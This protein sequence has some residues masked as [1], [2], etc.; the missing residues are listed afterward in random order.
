MEMPNLFLLCGGSGGG[1]GNVNSSDNSGIGAGSG[2]GGGGAL[3]VYGK[4]AQIKGTVKSAGGNGANSFNDDGAGGG[5]SGGAVIC[6]AK[7]SLGVAKAD[8]S[9]G[10][11]GT[12]TPVNVGQDGGSGSV[13]RVRFDGPRTTT[14]PVTSRATKFDGP[15]TDAS[16]TVTR[17]FTLTGSGNNSE[18]RIFVRPL[19][20][21]WS[22][23]ASVKNYGNKWQATVTLPGNDSN[24]LLAA[25]QRV[26]NP[27]SAKYTA[28][29]SWVLSQ[30]AANI[31]YVLCPARGIVA[32]D[33]LINFGTLSL[34]A[35][36]FDTI[37]ISNTGCADA[38][39]SA[40]IADPSLG[41][42][43]SNSGKPA[44]PVQTKD[45]IVL[46]LHPNTKGDYLHNS[47]RSH[48][49][50]RYYCAR[51][52][53]WRS[54]CSEPLSFSGSCRLWKRHALFGGIRYNHT[55]ESRLRFSFACR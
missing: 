7:I 34:C 13:G 27:A 12:G 18:V 8:V 30:A 20:G 9:V 2:G 55:S 44:I 42:S 54:I 23:E 50:W 3:I 16:D 11:G 15:S 46:H 25:A 36:V 24:Y 29:P 14:F 41:V 31:L 45:T 21:Q 32:S 38:T 33:S 4:S 48:I 53:D 10:V 51:H 39:L 17:T 19:S 1:G 40:S 22:Q 26:L 43:L 6:G 47:Y 5:G 37:V 52:M 35:D 28:E 49:R